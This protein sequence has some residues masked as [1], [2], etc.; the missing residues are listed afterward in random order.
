MLHSAAIGFPAG[1]RTCLA[2][3]NAM[4]AFSIPRVDTCLNSREG[5]SETLHRRGIRPIAIRE[6]RLRLAAI[7]CITL[8]PDA[9]PS[10]SPLQ[11]G[12]GTQ[13]GVKS[14]GHAINTA[15]RSDPAIDVLLSHEWARAMN[16]IQRMI[17]LPLWRPGTH[18][19]S[20]T[21][22]SWT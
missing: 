11:L 1:L 4:L 21:R 2:F 6:A 20:H 17:Y 3:V 22:T 19:A 16:T 8:L 9:G 7:V 14:T 12:V 18:P 10:R 15:L 5:A 13:G